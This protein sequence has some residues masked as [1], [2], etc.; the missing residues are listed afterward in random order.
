MQYS[1]FCQSGVHDGRK[2]ICAVTDPKYRPFCTPGVTVTSVMR[3]N[4]TNQ[5]LSSL[6]LMTVWLSLLQKT[7]H[8]LIQLQGTDFKITS[9]KMKVHFD[10]N[11]GAGSVT[12]RN[13][14]STVTFF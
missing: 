2:C 12:K 4:G 1:L 10:S 8:Q 14:N 11:K 5:I 3:V 9:Q 7:Q 13:N 6:L